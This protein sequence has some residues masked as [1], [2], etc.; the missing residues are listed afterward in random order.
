MRDFNGNIIKVGDKVTFPGPYGQTLVIG[1]VTKVGIGVRYTRA[2]HKVKV[3]INESESCTEKLKRDYWGNLINGLYGDSPN[4]GI[5][6]LNKTLDN[7]T[8]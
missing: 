5:L 4:R 2:Y 3:S 8:E 7:S 1:T 6:I